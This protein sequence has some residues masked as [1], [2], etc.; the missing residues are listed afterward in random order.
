[1]HR[2]NLKKLSTFLL[3]GIAICACTQEDQL[4]TNQITL[5]YQ[6]QIAT[7]SI[8]FETI[9]A[10]KKSRILDLD[11]PNSVVVDHSK[12]QF[13]INELLQIRNASSK[14][15]RITSYSAKTI[16]KV[17]VYLFIEEVGKYIHVAH[18]DSIP[19]FAQIDFRPKF[20]D[21]EAVYKSEDGQYISF[22]RPTLDYVRMKPRVVSP[23]PH[24]QMLQ[25]IK[26]QWTIRFS[27]FQW[28]PENP[29]GS[30]KELRA[31]MAREWVAITTNYAYM[32]TTPEYDFILSHFAEVMGGDLYD[33]DKVTFTPAKYASEKARFLQPH[34]FNCGH[35]SSSIGGLGGDSTWGISQW[36][37]YGHYAS[38]SGWEAIAHEFGHC[39]GYG[40]NSNMT[41]GSNGVGWTIFIA[42][43]HSYLVHKGDMPYADRNLLGFHFPENVK[44]SG[45]VEAKFM[46]DAESE[47]FYKNNRI[48]KYFEAHP[49]K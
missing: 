3:L 47:K 20:I 7:D 48:R 41:Y 2:T 1:M 9:P 33:N 21:G 13:K 36:N 5:P 29:N 28:S 44:Y 23:D 22:T 43:L 25:K 16:E 15:L 31:I 24:Y 8:C 11:E 14:E 6:P 35:T 19:R 38:Y 37:F 27:N 32:M 42:Y 45:G 10:N 4:E 18:F 17:D 30:W 39:K 46:S 26:A 49:L 34:T 40:H 12:R